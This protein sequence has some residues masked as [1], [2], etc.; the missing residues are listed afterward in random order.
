LTDI[1]RHRMVS[2]VE[3]VKPSERFRDAMK[4]ILSVPKAEIVKREG[5]YKAA[6]KTERKNRRRHR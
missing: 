1:K 4:K 2:T 6:R 3:P 5:E